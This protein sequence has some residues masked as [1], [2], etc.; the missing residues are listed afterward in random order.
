MRQEYTKDARKAEKKRGV[1]RITN[2][3]AGNSHCGTV[4]TNP[5]SIREDAGLIHDLAQWVKDLVLL[6]AVVQVTDVAEI[7]C[8]CVCCGGQQLQL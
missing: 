3:S 5:T 7:L 4:V 2:S 6:R 8:C 1:F